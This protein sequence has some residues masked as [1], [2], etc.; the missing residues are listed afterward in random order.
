[1]NQKDIAV[2]VFF[3]GLSLIGY[4]YMVNYNIREGLTSRKG[5]S[6]GGNS[7]SSKDDSEDCGLGGNAAGYASK[8]KSASTKISDSLNV[9]KYRSDYENCIMNAEDLV[10]NMMLKAALCID[11]SNEDNTKE[12]IEKMVALGHAKQVLNDI[13]KF[14][15]SQ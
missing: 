4:I 11:I 7:S 1:M 8:L 3:I 5:G 6:K 15:D 9:S 2:L 13:M 12:A 10:N 14:V